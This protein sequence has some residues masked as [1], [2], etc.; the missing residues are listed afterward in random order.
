VQRKTYRARICELGGIKGNRSKPEPGATKKKIPQLYQEILSSQVSPKIFHFLQ[1]VIG[2]LGH[3]R[4]VKLESLADAVGMPIRAE[5][6]R[7]RL[8]RFLDLY[9][10]NVKLHRIRLGESLSA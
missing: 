1:L 3:V 6:R 10:F 9:Q 7:K 2:A 4:Q 8:Q 5:S